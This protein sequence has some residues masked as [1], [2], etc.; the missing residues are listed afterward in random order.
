MH[1]G[2]RDRGRAWIRTT[3]YH[4]RDRG[5]PW[6]RTT[7]K[8][9]IL[10]LGLIN[11][12]YRSNNQLGEGLCEVSA[13]LLCVVWWI[14]LSIV[15]CLDTRMSACTVLILVEQ[16]PCWLYVARPPL[17]LSRYTN[18]RDGM[19]VAVLP[20]I[21]FV[22]EDTMCST[23]PYLFSTPLLTHIFSTTSPLNYIQY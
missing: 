4:A 10:L 7:S 16:G 19:V 2:D 13:I 14:S 5:R 6:I 9:T 11:N 20:D 12:W 1:A 23:L 21:I 17:V 15:C 8:V 3:S 18:C 22:G